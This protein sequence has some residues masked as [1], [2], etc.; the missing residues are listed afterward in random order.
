MFRCI[1]V[2]S[3]ALA[4]TTNQS[5]AQ[6][7]LLDS[8]FEFS[9]VPMLST[10]NTGAVEQGPGEGSS[11]TSQRA[12]DRTTNENF[13]GN[14][15]WLLQRGQ[16]NQVN[17]KQ[18]GVKNQIRLSQVGNLNE[19]RLLQDGRGNRMELK[20]SGSGNSMELTQQGD[21]NVASMTQDGT[22]HNIMKLKQYG[23]NNKAEYS[24]TGLGV[25]NI[26]VTQ[27]GGAI[28]KI[29]YYGN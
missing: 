21:G 5:S 17:F 14:I 3:L 7:I 13:E 19:A 8:G 18:I 9:S 15:S 25:P 16:S 23:D 12:A 6:N 24:H 26:R 22:L 4:L 2:V 29:S 20:Q 1:C 28:A 27:T 10:I 11:I